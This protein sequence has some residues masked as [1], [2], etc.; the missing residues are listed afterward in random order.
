MRVVVLYN[1]PSQDAAVDARDVLVQ[2]QTVGNAIR[3]LGHQSIE[4]AATLDLGSVKDRLGECQ[5]DLVFN[6]VES[7]GGTDRLMILAT[8]LLDALQIPYTGSKTATMLATA[9]KVA[10]K[11][12]LHS[13]GLP[14]PAWFAPSDRDAAPST[15]PPLDRVIVKS[16]WEHASFGLEVEAI[17]KSGDASSLAQRIERQQAAMGRPCFAEQFIDGREFNLSMLAGPLGPQVLPPAEID[18]SA[19]PPDSP[20]IVGYR[21]K[22]DQ[23]S[24]EYHN[25]PRRFDFASADAPLVDRLTQLAAACWELFDLGGY[26]RVDFRV[27]HEGQPWILEVNTNP[28]LS[29]DAGFAAALN[30]AGIE[31]DQAIQYILDD[32]RRA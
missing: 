29:P 12:R 16:I 10:A 18:F 20:R 9:N 3:A 11:Q 19:L 5:P 8:M 2:A 22:W 25:T 30:R 6:L 26:A 31:Y 1:E 14:T 23:Q 4:I 15:G 27:D 21:A 17:F 28:C 32:A 7:L 13:A 24:F